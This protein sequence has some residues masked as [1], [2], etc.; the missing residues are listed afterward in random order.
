MPTYIVITKIHYHIKLHQNMGISFW[1]GDNFLT[2]KYEKSS[3]GQES[4]SSITLNMTYIC[5]KWHQFPFST[6]SDTQSHTH[7]YKQCL[8]SFQQTDSF[9]WNSVLLNKFIL[10]NQNKTSN[11]YRFD[12]FE[13][14]S[15]EE[16]WYSVLLDIDTMTSRRV[17]KEVEM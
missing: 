14:P 2:K 17:E 13:K 10:H 11:L 6:F 7:R 15:S 8:L 4:R 3:E 16:S 5:R 1:V 9:R 12:L